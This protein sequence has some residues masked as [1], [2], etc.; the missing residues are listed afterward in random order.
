[1]RALKTT[2]YEE[3]YIYDL[4]PLSIATM[5]KSEKLEL[6]VQ[7]DFSW[8]REQDR[9]DYVGKKWGAVMGIGNAL[10]GLYSGMC[11]VDGVRPQ[12]AMAVVDVA[13]RFL[14]NCYSRIPF[15][16]MDEKMMI[17]DFSSSTKKGW[18]E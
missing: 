17:S 12:S 10:H 9:S 6:L 3:N 5:D 1:M 16:R 7:C 15:E 13:Y 4:H 8:W 11:V 14:T 2:R 18:I